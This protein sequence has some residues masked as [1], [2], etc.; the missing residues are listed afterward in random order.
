MALS[1][2]IWAFVRKLIGEE[3]KSSRFVLTKSALE[4]NKSRSKEEEFVGS[5]L[6]K[7]SSELV[8]AEV[9]DAIDKMEKMTMCVN[10]IMT[11]F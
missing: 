7:M 6:L 3:E 2:P 11:L 10:C 1:L 5:S 8:S 4:E 9:D